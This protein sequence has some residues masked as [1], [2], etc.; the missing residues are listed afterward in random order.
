MDFGVFLEY[1]SPEQ[2]ELLCSSFMVTA[3]GTARLEV[4]SSRE[5]E[6]FPAAARGCVLH[7]SG[8]PSSAPVV[9]DWWSRKPSRASRR[10]KSLGKPLIVVTSFGK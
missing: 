4:S 9:K 1:D 5:K 3:V 7:P 10:H 6:C 8:L 2:E